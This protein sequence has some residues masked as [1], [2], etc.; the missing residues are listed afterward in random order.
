MK[1]LIVSKFK[2]TLK[3]TDILPRVGDKIDI[4]FPYP[5]V[6]SVLLFPSKDSLRILND[7][8]DIDA[9][10]VITVD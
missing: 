4:W 3:E 2:A 9:D 7:G 5:S 1:L 10:A 8:V 6:A